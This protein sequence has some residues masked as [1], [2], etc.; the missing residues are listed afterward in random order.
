[1]KDSPYGY[2]EEGNKLDRRRDTMDLVWWLVALLIIWFLF[3]RRG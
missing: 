3:I 2:I 1:M